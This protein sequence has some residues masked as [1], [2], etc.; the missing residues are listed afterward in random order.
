MAE[1]IDELAD[2]WCIENPPALYHTCSPHRVALTVRHLRNYYTDDFAAQLVA[3]LPDWTAWLAARNGTPPELAER[4]C[5][6]ANGAPH[7]ELD[8]DDREGPARIA[9]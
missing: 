5:P 4:C 6:Y 7:P 1:L 8:T 3:L 9:E 2:S